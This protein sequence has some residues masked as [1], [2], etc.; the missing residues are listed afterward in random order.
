MDKDDPDLL[1]P[2]DSLAEIAELSPDLTPQERRFVY[3]RSVGSPPLVAFKNAGY[4]GTSWRTIETRPKIREALLDL[5][6]KLEPEYRVTQ[7]KVFAMLME[8]A[9]LARLKEQPKV[10]VE[11]AVA[12]ANISGVAAAS[13]LQ[14]TNDTNVTIE[15]RVSDIKA[16]RQLP[17][18][19]LEQMV[20]LER[21]LPEKV[22]QAEVIDGDFSEER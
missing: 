10:L 9:D 20:G 15:N 2:D 1:I 8:A 14:V 7:K 13:K 11:A 18:N 3:W 5:N 21:T 12:L 16:L 4:K 19:G 22:I 6:E 17:R